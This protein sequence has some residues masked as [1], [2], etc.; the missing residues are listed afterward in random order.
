MAAICSS[1]ELSRHMPANQSQGPDDDPRRHFTKLANQLLQCLE[2]VG[3]TKSGASCDD[4][5]TNAV[6]IA[7]LKKIVA[8]R[9]VRNRLFGPDLFADPAWDIMLDLAIATAEHRRISVSSLCIAANV[10]TTTALRNIKAMAEGGLIII[11]SDK[12]DGRR[13]HVKLSDSINEMMIKFALST[14]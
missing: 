11:V 8:A 3:G 7:R 9:A 12:H 13:K 10:P 5:D 14:I 1:P 6:A 2:L 4:V